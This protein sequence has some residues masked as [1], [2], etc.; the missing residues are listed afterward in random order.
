MII[1]SGIAHETK[2][3]ERACYHSTKHHFLP[4]AI[5]SSCQLVSLGGGQSSCILQNPRIH[6]NFKYCWVLFFC[7]SVY[8]IY[9]YLCVFIVK[10]CLFSIFSVQNNLKAQ[11]LSW[12]LLKSSALKRSSH[13]ET[14][15]SCLPV[16]P[17]MAMTRAMCITS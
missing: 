14:L 7:L 16:I 3:G 6:I 5:C 11:P 10:C 12:K 2:S 4:T 17:H 1:C 13:T 9:L 15:L 8:L